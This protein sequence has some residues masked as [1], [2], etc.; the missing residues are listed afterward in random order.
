MLIADDKVRSSKCDDLKGTD[1]PSHIDFRLNE[2]T[3]HNEN[4]DTKGI[5]NKHTIPSRGYGFI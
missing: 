1:T 5:V 4:G 2:A 3:F